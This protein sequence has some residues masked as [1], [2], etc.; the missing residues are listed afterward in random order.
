WG[1]QVQIKPIQQIELIKLI[2]HLIVTEYILG[3]LFVILRALNTKVIKIRSLL[4]GV[5]ALKYD[6][7]VL[8]LNKNNFPDGLE[9]LNRVSQLRKEWF[10]LEDGVR[11]KEFIYI[12]K[13]LPDLLLKI[14]LIIEDKIAKFS[15]FHSS[16][17]LPSGERIKVRGGYENRNL[18]CIKYGINNYVLKSKNRKCDFFV[19]K[20]FWPLFLEKLPYSNLTYDTEWTLS[21]YIIKIPPL[22]FSLLSGN[23]NSILKPIFEK[24]EKLIA[25]YLSFYKKFTGFGILLPPLSAP[26]PTLNI[27]WRGLIGLRKVLGR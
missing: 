10:G 19:K 15:P 22:L 20:G 5:S 13:E 3:L 26:L 21:D 23:L 7:E 25:D 16:F 9:L 8:G 14:L 6:L 11:I 18:F 17:P 1:K 27:K 4:C 24:R 12:L 2:E